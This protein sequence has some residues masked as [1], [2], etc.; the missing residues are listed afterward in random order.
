MMFKSKLKTRI[1]IWIILA[2]IVLNGVLPSFYNDVYAA[3]TTVDEVL[4]SAFKQQ[5]KENPESI[6]LNSSYIDGAIQIYLP[7]ELAEKLT[8][9]T[10][11]NVI[12]MNNTD[13]QASSISFKINDEITYV[14]SFNGMDEYP[15]GSALL[16]FNTGNIRFNGTEGICYIKGYSSDT[17]EYTY[18]Y[19]YVDANGEWHYEEGT[20]SADSLDNANVK[21]VL[22]E[23]EDSAGLLEHA[24]SIF[25]TLCSSMTLGILRLVAGDNLTIE[26]L[27]FNQYSPTS[28]SIFERMADYEN[29]KNTIFNDGMSEALT[30]TYSFFRSIAII[31]YMMI[32]VYMGVKILLSSTAEKGAKHRELFLYLIQG[33]IIL[34]LFPYVIRYTIELNNTFVQYICNL[35]GNG[36]PVY[37]SISAAE[38]KT[39]EGLG[40]ASDVTSE[41]QN[42]LEAGSDYMSTMY[43]KAMGQG[44]ITYAICFA[45]MVK[46]LIAFLIIYFKRLL[47]VVFLIAVFPLVSISYAIDKIGDGKSQAFNNW[48]KEFALNVFLQSFHAIVYVIG[49]AL[50]TEIGGGN[51]SLIIV[52]LILE[53]ISKGDEFLRNIFN[54]KGGGGQTVRG[55]ADSL[56]QAQVALNVANKTRN[57]VTNRFKPGS[58][59]SKAR[60][61]LN[62]TLDSLANIGNARAKNNLDNTLIADID[63]ELGNLDAEEGLAGIQD[64]SLTESADVLFDE[65]ATNAQKQAA[66]NNILDSMNGEGNEEKLKELADY[67]AQKYGQNA[68]K[69]LDQ[70]LKVKAAGNAIIAGKVTNITLN[71]NIEILLEAIRG[72]GMAAAIASG[73]AT[74]DE[75]KKMQLMSKVKFNKPKD[76]ENKK[77]KNNKSQSGKN[78]SK[79]GGKDAAR[80]R[81]EEA[82]RRGDRYAGSFKNAPSGKKGTNGNSQ[83]SGSGSTG[84]S[85]GNTQRVSGA[86]NGS[87]RTTYAPQSP[88]FGN[89]GTNYTKFGSTRNKNQANTGSTTNTSKPDYAPPATQ[90]T[91]GSNAN[92]GGRQKTM[93]SQADMFEKMGRHEDAKQLRE[94]LE[95]SSK[96]RIK[97][98][99]SRR[100]GGDAKVTP[101]TNGRKV[102]IGGKPVK[103]YVWKNNSK[104]DSD[105]GN[106]TQKVI[107]GVESRRGV[108]RNPVSRN[109]TPVTSVDVQSTDTKIEVL[110]KV[111]QAINQVSDKKEKTSSTFTNAID[112]KKRIEQFANPQNESGEKRQGSSAIDLKLKLDPEIVKKASRENIKDMMQEGATIITGRHVYDSEKKK[113]V[114]QKIIHYSNEMW[115]EANKMVSPEARKDETQR[116][117]SVMSVAASVAAINMISEGKTELSASET[118]EHIKN[119]RDVKEKL[120]TQ[121]KDLSMTKVSS[122]SPEEKAKNDLEIQNIKASLKE[123]EEVMKKLDYNLDDFEANLR[124]QILNDTS[125][126]DQDDPER[127]QIINSSIRY[128][129]N[130]LSSDSL[131]LAGLN[132]DPQELQIGVD[133]NNSEAHYT[134][135]SIASDGFMNV[136]ETDQA[137]MDLLDQK[138][139]IE[140]VMQERRN[141]IHNEGRTIRRDVAYTIKNAAY[142]LLDAGVDAA[143]I[144]V[145]LTMGGVGSSGSKNGDFMESSATNALVGYNLVSGSYEK[146]SKHVGALGQRANDSKRILEKTEIMRP[147]VTGKNNLA[148]KFEDAFIYNGR[149]VDD[150]S[151]SEYMGNMRRQAAKRTSTGGVS[152]EELSKQNSNVS[153]N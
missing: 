115:D 9:D 153:G 91:K 81:R 149:K 104:N 125:L 39:D 45:V 30:N 14:A 66:L 128:V 49:M 109:F 119:I 133:P 50:I 36:A 54:V 140:N 127:A 95:N 48:Y 105:T 139:A 42:S 85:A 57:A 22:A 21:T 64:L 145:G 107:I 76:N 7:A 93:K 67:V 1:A 31:A 114:P 138:R 71:Q 26:S 62:T 11:R 3:E 77:T 35:K 99:F 116:G 100:A 68:T 122:I 29:H 6:L 2:V 121:L 23:E 135:R 110:D 15:D 69:Q 136:S 120:E 117:R 88:K 60:A 131:F 19:S 147:I 129:Q 10:S 87:T 134:K 89:G 34:F 79:S 8:Y 55:I 141:E 123:T 74:E 144:S 132:Y 124:I 102:T 18:Q 86:G 61:G 32:T 25:I 148:R 44:W 75:L 17:G 130:N 143:S 84:A 16:W 40:A 12:Q 98:P 20:F 90:T 47:T 4:M 13:N 24:I 96:S 38:D 59:L 97:N 83:A 52:I 146:V 63:A 37:G 92:A 65:N 51:G 27:I 41:V 142:T 150:V 152:F 94:K 126:I 113:S 46:Q 73:I 72:N 43:R 82:R 111:N 70:M 108:S 5:V 112:Q 118:L 137:R 106:S 80:K 151:G 53:F 56:V 33:A 103:V 28:L 101:R 78:S 58:H